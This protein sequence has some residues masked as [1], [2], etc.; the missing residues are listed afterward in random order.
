MK[1]IPS[2]ER[3][4]RTKC[5]ITKEKGYSGYVRH[6][7]KEFDF[8]GVMNFISFCVRGFSDDIP[9]QP[10]SWERGEILCYQ[11]RVQSSG[12]EKTTSKSGVQ[13]ACI[14]VFIFDA[15]E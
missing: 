12:K 10:A 5:A 4:D 13:L 8:V 3:Y 6:G 1:R 11:K 2:S 15:I 14:C 9:R 7:A